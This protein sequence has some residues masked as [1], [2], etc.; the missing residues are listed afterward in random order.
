MPTQQC[1]ELVDWRAQGGPP[2]CPEGTRLR[3]VAIGAVPTGPIAQENALALALTILLP[4]V[5]AW[6]DQ[7]TR[8]PNLSRLL[9]NEVV[10]VAAWAVQ[11]FVFLN[12]DYRG[13]GAR[14][15]IR[16]G[17]WS[18]VAVLIVMTVLFA[19]APVHQESTDFWPRYGTARFMLEYRLVYLAYLAFAIVNI[20]RHSWNYAGMADQ[21]SLSVGLRLVAIGGVLGG[22]Y[23]THEGLRVTALALG[24][25]NAFL[26]S[27]TVTR[28]FIAGSVALMV[29]GVTM[30]AWGN[31]LHI[32]NLYYWLVRH[33]MYRQL[34]PLWHALYETSPRLALAP[35]RSRLSDALTIRDLEFRLYRRIVEVRDGSLELRPYVDPGVIERARDLSRSADL[36]EEEAQAVVEAA[37]LAAAPN[38]RKMGRAP[39]SPAFPFELHGGT[40][41]SSEGAVLVRV[42][43][44]FQTSPIVEAVVREVRQGEATLSADSEATAGHR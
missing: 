6:I 29:A 3:A 15:R 33:Q 34:H 23:V 19:H 44:Y 13:D 2:S 36:P 18:L 24:I 39:H 9:G 27:D 35:P 41:V 38:A 22:A 20:I 14:S 16:F 17:S 25:H 37:S 32:P 8:S 30:P 7:V 28:V 5:A 42:A 4:S 43:R 40:D 1:A 26:D 31:R 11:I 10:L 12:L 21:P